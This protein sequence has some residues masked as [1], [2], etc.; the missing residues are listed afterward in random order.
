MRA[1]GREQTS[2]AADETLTYEVAGAQQ[3]HQQEA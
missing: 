3:G 2:L 1:L